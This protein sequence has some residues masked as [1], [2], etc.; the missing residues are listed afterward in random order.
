[1]IISYNKSGHL[2]TDVIP[3]SYRDHLKL[4]TPH[5]QFLLDIAYTSTTFK[6]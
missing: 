6:T 2:L 5:I 4:K 1:M 3:D